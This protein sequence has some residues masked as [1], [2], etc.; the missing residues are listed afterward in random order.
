MPA[1]DGHDYNY[2]RSCYYYLIWKLSSQYYLIN[3]IIFFVKSKWSKTWFIVPD[4]P[5]IYIQS[6][7][8]IHLHIPTRSSR[9]RSRLSATF[10]IRVDLVEA[11]ID[12]SKTRPD[13]AQLTV[14]FIAH[15]SSS[16]GFFLFSLSSALPIQ[17]LE[18]RWS[19]KIFYELMF[20]HFAWFTRTNI[21]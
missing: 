15:C 11:Y 5:P 6:S 3:Q 14:S 9:V 1:G 17:N 13:R 19:A 21:V 16:S 2:N 18:K 7:T 10:A 8:K 20:K 4:E 12:I